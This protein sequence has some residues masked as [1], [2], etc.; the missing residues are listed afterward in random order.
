MTNVN[1]RRFL[2]RSL[3]TLGAG[4][5]A[6]AAVALS[7]G[8]DAQAQDSGSL[9]E[10]SRRLGLR[11]LDVRIPFDGRHQSGVLTARPAQATYVAL[12]SIAPN[13]AQ[14]FEALLTLS[15]RARQLSQGTVVG[16]TAVDEPPPDSGILG[17]YDAPDS[18]TINISFGHSLFDNRYDLARHKP[19]HLEPM[20]PFT[21][22]ELDPART[23]GDILLQIAAGQ[24]DTVTHTV[25]ELMRQVSG[26]LAV[27]WM[28]DGFTAAQRERDPRSS[29]RNLFAFKDG[30]ANPPSDDASMMDRLIWAGKGVGEP[31]FA[32]NGTYVIVRVIRQHVEFWDRVGM[33]EQERMIGRDRVS[34]APLGGTSQ[35]ESPDFSSDPHGRRIPLSAHIRLANPRT[36]ATADQRMIRRSYNYDRGVD[37]AGDLDCGLIFTAYNQNPHRQFETIQ[38]R[39]ENEPMIDYITPVGGGYFFAPRG[40]RGLGDWVGSGLQA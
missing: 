20:R 17:P 33:L 35:F 26:T 29:T 39:L 13:Q 14:L 5:A 1:R 6:A 25:R 10:Q 34:G 28:L 27:R 9:L 36:P 21:H 12:D 3:T 40:A 22:D 30:T 38:V 32:E 19:L 2:T 11:E 37:E 7:E 8:G 4:G 31:P 18:L 16:E 23:G 15:S 24:R